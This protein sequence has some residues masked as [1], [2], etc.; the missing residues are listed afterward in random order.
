MYW[1]SKRNWA[2][3]RLIVFPFPLRHDNMPLKGFPVKTEL[4]GGWTIPRSDLHYLKA[5]P[6]ASEGLHE[7]LV[8]ADIGWRRILDVAKQFAPIATIFS[9]SVTVITNWSLVVQSLRPLLMVFPH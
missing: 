9:A 6:L 5:G 4:Q 8:P 3:E 1:W 7:I 2:T